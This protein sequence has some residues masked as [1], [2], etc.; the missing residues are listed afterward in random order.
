MA[1]QNMLERVTFVSIVSGASL[2]VG[3]LFSINNNTW[4]SSYQYLNDVLPKIKELLTGKDLQMRAIFKL[5][6]NPWHINNRANVLADTMSK[7]WGINMR[8]LRL[9]RH[10]IGNKSIFEAYYIL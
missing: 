5:I 9:P 1:E 2:A 7:C 4:P 6:L 3:L 10:H 8:K